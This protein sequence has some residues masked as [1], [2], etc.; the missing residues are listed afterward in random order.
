MLEII[1]KDYIRT[2]KAKGL[3]EDEVFYKHALRNALLPFT[4]MF[5][6]LLPALISGSVIIETIFAWPGMGR[7]GYEAMLAR[8]Y[9]VIIS[10]LFIS[11]VLTLAGTF[12][13]DLLYMV[14]DPRI[15]L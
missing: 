13:S 10:L 8:D 15:R 3:P 7:L 2:A 11:A 5:G 4:T 12:I 14:V 9:P 6:M 1:D